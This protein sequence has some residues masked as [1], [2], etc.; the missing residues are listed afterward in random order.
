MK[1]GNNDRNFWVIVLVYNRY[2]KLTIARSAGNKQM[3]QDIACTIPLLFP[4][5]V[6]ASRFVT[7]TALSLS[8]C[9]YKSITIITEICE[10]PATPHHNIVTCTQRGCLLPV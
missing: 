8:H 10:F 5:M 7:M 6:I 9:R 1:C 4:W 2:C 3:Y